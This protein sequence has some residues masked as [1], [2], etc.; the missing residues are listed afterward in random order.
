MGELRRHFLGWSQPVLHSAADLLID[1]RL[2]RESPEWRGAIDLSAVLIALPGGR[3][4]RRLIELLLERS[5]AIGRPLIPPRLVTVGGLPEELYRPTHSAPPPL[6][7]TL[8]WAAAIFEAGAA[9][10][11]L[12]PLLPGKGESSGDR[13][14]DAL[15]ATLRSSIAR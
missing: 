4:G 13:G 1:S 8:A 5:E 10:A 3:A 7:E 14:R 11:E 12:S 9:G 2:V 15:A 6:V